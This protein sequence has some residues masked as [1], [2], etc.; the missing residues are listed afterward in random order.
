MKNHIQIFKFQGISEFLLNNQHRLGD[1]LADY[2]K[3]LTDFH[4]TDSDFKKECDKYRKRERPNMPWDSS[5][6]LEVFEGINERLNQ[7]V[8]ASNPNNHANGRKIG[9]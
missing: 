9:G 4:L 8:I 7:R 5:K 1:D 2:K 6:C 3:A